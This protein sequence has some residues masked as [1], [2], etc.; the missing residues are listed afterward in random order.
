MYGGGARAQLWREDAEQEAVPAW[1]GCFTCCLYT[2]QF[3]LAVAGE[4]PWPAGGVIV[5]KLAQMKREPKRCFRARAYL[6]SSNVASS[7]PLL[8]LCPSGR[9]QDEPVCQVCGFNAGAATSSLLCTHM[10]QQS[11]RLPLKQA[12][13]SPRLVSFIPIR[14]CSSISGAAAG[15]WSGTGANH[16]GNALQR[17]SSS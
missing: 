8:D 3:L 1:L 15:G 11:R 2:C 10:D 6:C 7:I 9:T 16:W 14:L 17:G 13:C 12:F 5:N 4:W